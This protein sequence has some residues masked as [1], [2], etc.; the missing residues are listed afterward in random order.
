MISMLTNYLIICSM[1]PRIKIENTSYCN[2]YIYI[3]VYVIFID[4]NLLI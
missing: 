1:Y 3:V 4:T 2:T